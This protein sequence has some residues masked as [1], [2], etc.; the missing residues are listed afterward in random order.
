MA[1]IEFNDK[2]NSRIQELEQNLEDLV[3]SKT[4]KGMCADTSKEANAMKKKAQLKSKIL[5]QMIKMST[6]VN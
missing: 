6:F 5:G 4:Q 1:K 2:L 3:E